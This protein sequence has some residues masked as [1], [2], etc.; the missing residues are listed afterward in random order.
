MTL[1]V[2]REKKTLGYSTTETNKRERIADECC[3]Q[4]R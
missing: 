4:R 3:L 1:Q 2:L